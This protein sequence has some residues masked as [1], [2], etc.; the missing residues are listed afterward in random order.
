[1]TREYSEAVRLI[2]TF[3]KLS[4]HHQVTQKANGFEAWEGCGAKVSLT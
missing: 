1:M 2:L 4:I 3:N